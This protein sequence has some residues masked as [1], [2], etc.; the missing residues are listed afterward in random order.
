MSKLPP[1]TIPASPGE[2]PISLEDFQA[3]IGCPD[4][5]VRGTIDARGPWGIIARFSAPCVRLNWKKTEYGSIVESVTLYGWRTMGN[6]RESGYNLEG[7]V[8]VSGKKTSAYTSSA[9]WRLPDGRLVSSSTINVRGG[10]V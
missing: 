9:L 5:D 8:S 10:Y 4:D 7:T 1:L 2:I 3:Y 6:P